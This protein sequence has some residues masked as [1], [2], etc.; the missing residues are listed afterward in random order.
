MIETRPVPTMV[1]ALACAGASQGRAAEEP[2]P[3]PVPA[4]GEHVSVALIGEHTAL[5]PG[6]S[7]Q[8]G[9]LLRHEPHWHTYWIN[10]GDS[11]LPTTLAWTLPQ[12]FKAADIDWPVPKR[13]DVGGLYNFGYDAEVVLPITLAVPADAKAGTSAHLSV[14]AKWLVCREECIPGK[15]TL[16]LDLPIVAEEAKPDARWTMQFA[17]AR[18]AAPQAT[19][20]KSET[21]LDGERIRITL[22]GPSLPEKTDDLDAFVETRR[23]V[24]NQRPAIRRDGEALTIEFGKSEYFTAAPE[25]IDLVVTQPSAT[26]ARGW[27]VQVPFAAATAAP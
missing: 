8:L 12:G 20:W 26:G 9:L 10:P 22:R 1:L 19:A 23:V 14:D 4:A 17:R 21:R 11:G 15:A 7:S 6:Q 16:T 13:F 2:A 25:T 3:A 18:L 27:R 24:D 5:V